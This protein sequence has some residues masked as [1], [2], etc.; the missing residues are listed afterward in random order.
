[1]IQKGI[2]LSRYV[3]EVKDP[4]PTMDT[5]TKEHDQVL[6]EIQYTNWPQDGEDT[7]GYRPYYEEV[8]GVIV[9]KWEAVENDPTTIR[10]EIDRLKG[11]LQEGDY[12]VQKNAEYLAVGAEPPYDLME[13]HT[14]R[15]AWRDRIN[16]LEALLATIPE[17]ITTSL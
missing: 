1:M 10:L 2:I 6:K 9:Q 8:D 16:E 17:A 5:A 3:I 12:K 11:L 13:L 15:Q 14:T 4:D 7:T